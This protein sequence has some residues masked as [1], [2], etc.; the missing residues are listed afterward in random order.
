MVCLFTLRD[1]IELIFPK[2]LARSVILSKAKNPT[3]TTLLG[4]FALLRM[5]S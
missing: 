2:E 3:L 5:T 4:F 1:T